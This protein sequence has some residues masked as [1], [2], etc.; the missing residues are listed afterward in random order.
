MLLYTISQSVRTLS[1]NSNKIHITKEY[2][3][4]TLNAFPPTDFLISALHLYSVLYSLLSSVPQPNPV[5]FDNVLE[6]T[7]MD[8]IFIL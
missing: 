5:P 1:I 4:D 6:L 7:G 8:L 3:L 2:L